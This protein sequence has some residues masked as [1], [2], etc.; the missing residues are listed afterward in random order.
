MDKASPFRLVTSRRG[1]PGR[2]FGWEICKGDAAI[3]VA[4]SSETFRSR[5]EA[6]T[7]G[8]RTLQALTSR[9]RSLLGT[10]ECRSSQGVR[11][12]RCDI[13]AEAEQ[14]HA[15][16]SVAPACTLRMLLAAAGR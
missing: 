3:E 7:D 6:I 12:Q 5:H 14:D 11:A 1:P 15:P 9:P 10:S 2:P 13:V 8:E 4:R 16:L